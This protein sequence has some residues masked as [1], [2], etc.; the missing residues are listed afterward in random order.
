MKREDGLVR[1]R[2]NDAAGNDSS[3]SRSSSGE[4][5]DAR[6]NT[7]SGPALAMQRQCFEAA[8]RL[9]IRADHNTKDSHIDYCRLTWDHRR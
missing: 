7:S 6:D 5:G 4:K 8:F 2:H 3:G 1:L 9:A